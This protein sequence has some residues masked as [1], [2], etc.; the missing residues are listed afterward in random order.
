MDCFVYVIDGC[1]QY[2]I[3]SILLYRVMKCLY[4]QCHSPVIPLA[5]NQYT[6]SPILVQQELS[7]ANQAKENTTELIICDRPW[8]MLG[9][10][11]IVKFWLMSAM[12]C[13]GGLH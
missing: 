3:L 10:I 12:M 4:M 7:H 1:S 5:Y 13:G 2:Q 11:K 8:S 6:H 9:W